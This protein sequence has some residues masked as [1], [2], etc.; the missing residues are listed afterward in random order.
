MQ[1][2]EF[3]WMGAKLGAPVA[4]S[5]NGVSTI[6]LRPQINLVHDYKKKDQ[7]L[8]VFTED[9]SKFIISDK[10]ELNHI[11]GMHLTNDYIEQTLREYCNANL[12]KI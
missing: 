3:I 6:T 9:D 4:Q 2:H 8:V 12:Q 11:I 5:E 1:Q 10:D 7:T